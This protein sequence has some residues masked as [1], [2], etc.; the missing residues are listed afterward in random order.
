MQIFPIFAAQKKRKM[1]RRHLFWIIPS[2]LA[3]IVVTLYLLVPVF[4]KAHIHRKI[5]QFEI[6]R[7][8]EVSLQELHVGLLSF[9][10]ELPISLQSA[11]LRQKNAGDTLFYLANMKATIQIIKGLHRSK[12]LLSFRSDTILLHLILQD[13]YCNYKF[14]NHHSTRTPD[15]PNASVNYLKLSEKVF[16]NVNDLLPK[17]MNISTLLISADL[18]DRHYKYVIPDFSIE[19][20]VLCGILTEQCRTTVQSWRIDGFIDHAARSYYATITT[21]GEPSG[22][23]IVNELT[24][25]KMGFQRLEGKLS[26]ISTDDKQSQYSLCFEADGLFLNHRYIATQTVSVD[27]AAARLQLTLS[28]TRLTLDSSSVLVLN[29]AELHPYLNYERATHAKPHVTFAVNE[30]SRD[31]SQLFGSLPDGLFQVLPALQLTG[32]LDFS[33]RFDCDFNEV[34]SLDFDFAIG[35]RDRSLAI[36]GDKGRITRF[37]APFDYVSFANDD[38]LRIVAIGP[39]NPHFCPFDQIPPYLTKSILATEDAGF[40]QHRGFI[41]SSIREALVADIKSGKLRRGGSTLTMQLAKNLFLSRNKVFSRKFEEMILVWLIEDYHL[42]S[43]ERLF[44]I[45]VNIAEWGPDIIGIGEASDF[46]FGK[47]PQELTLGECLYLAS[48]I[49]APKHYRSTLDDYGNVIDSKREE[50]IFVARRMLE[51]EFITEDEFNRFNSFIHTRCMDKT[52]E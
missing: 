48:L 51:R 43:K 19:K 2:S 52:D 38:T 40:F 42:I 15:E 16:N 8:A 37:N 6:E 50:L 36:S 11:T 10:G 31:A 20:G 18:H 49:R 34:D 4:A 17:S 24:T 3:V 32:N 27:S 25:A 47:K 12:D 41:K 26:H 7:N 5:K 29:E 30:T 23:A 9:H 46:Y 39:T 22:F 45:Y 13:D 14:L 35:S 1:N 44:E 21:M 28:P 33:L